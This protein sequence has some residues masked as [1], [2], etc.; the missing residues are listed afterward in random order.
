MN[1]NQYDVLVVG[2]GL[3]S[4]T[5]ACLLAKDGLS[6]AVL[7]QNYL[8][9]G[10]TSSYWRKGFVFESGATT[11]VG[12]DENMP[13]NY[14]LKTLEI[15][16]PATRL[17]LPMKVH[18]SDGKS[19]NRYENLQNWISE[20]ERIFGVKN[21]RPF[22]EFCYQI[23]RFVWRTSLRQ[24][25]FP[26][27][28]FQDILQAVK[29]ISLEQIKFARYAL[30]SMQNLLKKFE[31]DKNQKFVQFVDEQLLIT[32]QN[33]SSEVNILFGA[34]ALCYTNYGNY[35]LNG[36]LINLVKPLIDFLE[37][38]DGKLFLRY[39]VQKIEQQNENY[40]ITCRLRGNKV[41]KLTAKYL[42]SG[43]PIN[44]LVEV[45]EES[46]FHEKYRSK[47]MP[48]EKLNGAFQMGI[49]F[50]PHRKYKSIH[51]QIHLESPLPEIES[52][53]IFL[54]LNHP[55]DTSRTDKKNLAVASVST[56][57]SHPESRPILDKNNLE[58][59]ILETLEKHDLVL[60]KNVVYQH[61]SA[62]KSWEKWTYRKFGA[63]G[64]YP[65]YFQ[66]KPWQ[67]PD[68]RAG[69]GLYLCGDTVYPGQGIPGVT[70]GGIIAYEKLKADKLEET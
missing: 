48:S 38:N 19:L 15:E 23:S 27:S 66:I 40:A 33:T 35:Y 43:I 10:C 45:L 49:G 57:V 50:Q 31:L 63:V 28:N 3:G 13:L 6:V 36:G 47:L 20:A 42:V 25:Y 68:A 21:Q 56:H 69:N 64:G 61:S 34:T 32:A 7:E 5:T 41:E 29:N 67:M 2:S 62:P 59:V 39:P 1:P 55:E 52:N 22:W 4:L 65:Q 53:S 12:L 51:H 18:F 14:L 16:L 60:R 17:D 11:L 46:D 30:I 26:P 8:P 9:G 24:K 54:S 44:N 37:K 70:L 58:N